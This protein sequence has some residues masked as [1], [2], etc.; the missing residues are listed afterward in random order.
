MAGASETLHESRE[1]LREETLDRHRALVSLQE[2]LE[3]VDWYNQRADATGD[4]EL[5]EVLAHNG[6]EEKEHAVMVLEWLRRHDPKFDQELRERLFAEG[7][8]V[9]HGA[10]EG[11]AAPE[12]AA[13]AAD[14]SLGIG[15]LKQG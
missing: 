4:P 7:P 12:A 8:I 6:D 3:A 14:G 2:E 9:D 11:E 5:A 10:P 13:P 15:S 1:K